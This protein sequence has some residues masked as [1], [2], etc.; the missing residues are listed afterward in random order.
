MQW[1]T[2]FSGRNDDRVSAVQIGRPSVA[3]ASRWGVIA[4][5][6]V[7]EA[8]AVA[9]NSCFWLALVLSRGTGSVEKVESLAVGIAV[10]AFVHIALQ[11]RGA[12]DF[13]EI[14]DMRRSCKSALIGWLLSAGTL[15]FVAL[16][17]VRTPS[18][19]R[20]VILGW[21]A[22]LAT[23]VGV[24]LTVARVADAL[25]R[26]RW[27]QHNILVIGSGPEAQRCAKLLRADSSGA[28]VVG[29]VSVD[30]TSPSDCHEG[31]DAAQLSD[32]QRLI[33]AKEVKDVIISTSFQEQGKLADLI[34]SLLWLPVRVFLW[35][36][37]LGVQTGLLT[38]S[39]YRMADIPLFLVG[40]PPLDGWHWVIK[41]VR[42]RTFALLL[43]ISTSPVL[44]GIVLLI[45]LTSP[46]PILFKQQREGYGGRMFT[47]FKFRTMRVDGSP[48]SRLILTALDDPRVFPMGA[49]LR[50][51]SL[52]ELPQLINVICGDMWLVGPRPH[53]PLATAAGQQYSTAVFGYMARLRVKPGITGWAQVNGRRGPTDTVEQIQQRCHYDLQYIQYLSLWF[54]LQ[55]LLQTAIKGF[56]HK[57]AY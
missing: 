37:S 43:L 1:L 7:A 45:R 41:D 26:A 10:A 44:L 36:P 15:S 38:R 19:G 23:L 5:L 12:Y 52:D 53:S 18:V 2:R 47:I 42:D 13:S 46:G 17:F 4:A 51:T 14:L 22:G 49:L 54:D 39:G 21:L 40:D 33:N 57:N 6:Q 25:V 27:L 31:V 8:L 3:W 28:N 56:I 24:R 16:L 11:Y 20:I 30:W 32:L 9:A 50:K 55:I 35:P 29:L 48:S 34:R